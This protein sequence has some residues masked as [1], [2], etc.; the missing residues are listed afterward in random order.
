MNFRF[1]RFLF[2]LGCVTA[3]GFL[4]W[5]AVHGERGLNQ[6]EQRRTTFVELVKT[7]SD[8]AD[9]RDAFARRVAL[10]RSGNLDP[11]MLDERAREMLEFSHPDDVIIFLSR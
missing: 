5:T 4:A 7:L 11:D 1:A 8:E 6:L 3:A 9:T 10:M 2:P